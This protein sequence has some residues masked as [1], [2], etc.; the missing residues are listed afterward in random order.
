MSEPLYNAS[1]LQA[2]R[3]FWSKYAVFSGRAGRAEYWW[4]ALASVIIS[5]LLQVVRFLAL[6]ASWQTYPASSDYSLRWSSLPWAVWYVATFVPEQ[7]LG[8]RRLHD[9]DR[10]GWWQL[11][12]FPVFVAGIVQERLT[13]KTTSLTH[14][15]PLTGVRLADST[16]ASVV[17]LV[18][19]VVLIL[20]Y[21]AAPTA[22]GRRFDQT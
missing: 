12:S 9:S 22:A 8:V 2:I 4:W 10:S 17:T 1:P 11:L 20:F 13:S 16:V 14:V 6:G 21:T 7:A 15:Q 5:L 19:T 3:R 18:I